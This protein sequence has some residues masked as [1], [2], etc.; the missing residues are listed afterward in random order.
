MGSVMRRILAVGDDVPIV[1]FPETVS[2]TVLDESAAA[3][4]VAMPRGFR[5]TSGG[6]ETR[7]PVSRGV[8][9]S[10]PSSEVAHIL[11]RL[12]AID[13]RLSALER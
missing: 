7:V 5:A 6:V 9:L 2:P 10:S 1:E 8:A 13:R 4:A 3:V 11:A 12:D